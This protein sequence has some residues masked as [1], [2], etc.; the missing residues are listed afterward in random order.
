MK[1]TLIAAA[2]AF[3]ALAAHATDYTVGL[4]LGSRH[5]PEAANLHDINP[6]VYVRLDNGLTAGVYH[7][8]FKRT[9]IYLG[10]TVEHGPFALTLGAISGYQSRVVS[11]ASTHQCKTSLTGWCYDETH[12]EGHTR[13]AIGLLVAPSVALP[14]VFGITPRITVLPKFTA[15]G[16]T[17]AHL[18]IEHAF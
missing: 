14:S 2:L 16:H 7:N 6:G 13:G 3:T 15:K 9:S 10:Y 5:F 8:S 11:S 4:H 1:R 17:V 12:E 18:S